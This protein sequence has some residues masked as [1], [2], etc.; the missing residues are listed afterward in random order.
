ME[1]T[2]GGAVNTSRSV[3][4]DFGANGLT[5]FNTCSL[6]GNMYTDSYISIGDVAANSP[7][8]IESALQVCS[9]RQ[10]IPTQCGADLGT[11]NGSWNCGMRSLYTIC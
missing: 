8:V 7:L 6:T 2:T 5:E 3:C 11:E 10:N 1:T 9:Y 4:Q